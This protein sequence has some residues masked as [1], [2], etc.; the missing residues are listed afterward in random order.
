MVIDKR[1]QS[2]LFMPA[3]DATAR[4]TASI[5]PAG[6]YREQTDGNAPGSI[7]FEGARKY[8]VLKPANEQK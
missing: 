2:W 7:N 1:P 4:R 6:A 3:I 5:P 8:S